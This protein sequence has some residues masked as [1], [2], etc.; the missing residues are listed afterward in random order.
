MVELLPAVIT[1]VGIYVLGQII[2]RFILEPIQ[3]Q[4][5][6]VGEIAH[7]LVFSGNVGGD[8]SS[9]DEK[10]NTQ[11]ELRLSAARLRASMFMI[12]FYGIFSL[13]GL[14]KPKNDI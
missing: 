7:A 3:E 6:I 12:P 11:N 14:V 5:K 2:V 13:I 9:Q 4:H 10:R 1:G 8:F